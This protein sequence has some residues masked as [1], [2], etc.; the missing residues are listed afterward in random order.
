MLNV[1]VIQMDVAQ[2]DVEAN[3]EKG[4]AMI[5]EAAKR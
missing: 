2:G 4:S 3:L 1:S 5:K